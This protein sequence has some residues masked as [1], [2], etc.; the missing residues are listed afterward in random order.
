M[1]SLVPN[2]K[3][4]LLYIIIVILILIIFYY[5]VYPYLQANNFNL[6]ENFNTKKSHLSNNKKVDLAMCSPS[7]CSTQFPPSFD[8]G[9]DPR[10]KPGD[11]GTK[12]FPSN[13]NCLGNEYNGVGS[14]CA[15][16]TKEQHDFLSSRGGNI[17]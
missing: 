5:V 2:N 12:Y 4:D 11:I 15:C 7:C 8:T 3:S 10:I 14:S 6:L 9:S 1:Y 16:I 17:V 13:F